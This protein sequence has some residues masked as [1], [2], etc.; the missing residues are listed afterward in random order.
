MSALRVTDCFGPEQ[1]V[2]VMRVGGVARLC[3]SHRVARRRFSDGMRLPASGALGRSR[4]FVLSLGLASGAVGSSRGTADEAHRLLIADIMARIPGA[5]TWLALGGT[6]G[7]A[8]KLT[9][10]VLGADWEP[11]AYVKV[12]D[13]PLARQLIHNEG[14]V[15]QALAPGRGPAVIADGERG[16]VSWVAVSA[17][18]GSDA[19][20]HDPVP[21]GVLSASA[22]APSKVL[23]R[24]P[25]RDTLVPEDLD[26]YTR[27]AE[28]SGDRLFPVGVTH[29]DAAPWNA[30]VR[31]DGVLCLF[32]WE[33]GRLD[34][35]PD[36]DVAHWSIQSARLLDK[37]A[38]DAAVRRGVDSVLACGRYDRLGAVAVCAVACLELASRHQREGNHETVAWWRQA[39][40]IAARECCDRGVD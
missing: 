10:V 37:C 23:G 9:L 20:G 2:W 27:L 4:R 26:A 24:H 1:P 33:Y 7:P 32:D 38:P 21:I 29:G 11:T 5:Q 18:G 17:L 40:R 22:D 35:L 34:G 31:R 6:P 12:G 14:V 39:A 3:T 19:R 8:Q 30:V 28:C 15:V 16:D 13:T 25:V 36:T